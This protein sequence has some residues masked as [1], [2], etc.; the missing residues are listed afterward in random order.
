MFLVHVSCRCVL[1]DRFELWCRNLHLLTLLPAQERWHSRGMQPERIRT[2]CLPGCLHRT[3]HRHKTKFHKHPSRKMVSRVVCCKK[4]CNRRSVGCPCWSLSRNQMDLRHSP[5][6]V[7]YK[8]VC[9]CL[10]R[11][12]C[13]HHKRWCNFRNVVNQNS[14][15]SHSPQV[16]HRNHS[17]RYHMCNCMFR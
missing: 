6:W 10:R 15:P 12:R 1:H 5:S 7:V 11:I 2:R 8:C 4:S 3:I 17:T 13:F 16:V 9:M 14:Y